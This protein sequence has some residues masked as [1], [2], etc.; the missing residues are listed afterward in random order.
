MPKKI[1]HED[2][3]EKLIKKNISTIPLEKYINSSTKIKHQC[4]C[5]NIWKI[6]PNNALTGKTCGCSNLKTDDEYKAELVYKNI[7]IIPLE[8]YKGAEIKILHKCTCGNV[9]K[10]APH[11][12][13]KNISKC[14]CENNITNI[15][16]LN[17]LNNKEIKIKPLDNYNGYDVKIRHKCTCGNI[18]RVSP[19][20]VLKNVKCGCG[21]KNNAWN[22]IETYRGRK[23]ILYYVKINNLWKIGLTLFERF[24][25]VED[26]ILKQRF[27]T[28]I[29]KD[30]ISIEILSTKVY[31]EGAEA[32]IMEDTLLKKY[33]SY[34][35]KYISD[36]MNWFSG[37]SEL[38]ISNIIKELR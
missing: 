1:T 18:W 6:T 38:F 12:V 25:T 22:N 31:N 8:K 29:K 9:W 24:D 36:D 26:S 34:K 32:Y 33:D 16:Y 3:K 4:K 21:Y 14:G 5:G 27:G 37:Y 11:T 35:Y 13:L 28:N 23:T 19:R 10:V 15:D 7:K 17:R 2:Y 30:N 20:N